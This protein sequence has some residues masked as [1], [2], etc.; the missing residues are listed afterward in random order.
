MLEKTNYLFQPLVPY[1]TTNTKWVGRCLDCGE[2]VDPKY[3]SVVHTGNGFCKHCSKNATVGSEKAEADMARETQGRWVPNDPYPGTISAP[4]R[5]TC[6]DCGKE[7]VTRYNCVVNSGRGWCCNKL[8]EMGRNN[9]ISHDDAVAAMN[10]ACNGKFMPSEKYPGRNDIPWKG[11]C[12]DCG[13]ECSPMYFGCVNLNKG[14]CVHCGQ[15]YLSPSQCQ[16]RFDRDDGSHLAL[17]DLYIRI[18]HD[19]VIKIG[20]GRKDDHRVVLAELPGGAVS[21]FEK[22]LLTA[23]RASEFANTASEVL[24][25]LPGGTDRWGTSETF[26]DP[27]NVLSGAVTATFEDLVVK[28]DDL[29]EFDIWNHAADVIE[30]A[31]EQLLIHLQSKK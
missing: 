19:G 3:T 10:K 15:W 23:V 31:K 24:E 6:L 4:W 25:Q 12:A 20:A 30:T 27:N 11:T 2:I 18:D 5:G 22:A 28:Y 14:H 1:T 26:D 17:V 7:A 16:Q 13:R 9:A 29:I 8:A 21:V